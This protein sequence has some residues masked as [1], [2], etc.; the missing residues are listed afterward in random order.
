MNPKR[1]YHFLHQPA[2]PD[3]L[4][5]T[6]FLEESEHVLLISFHSGLI[7]RIYAEHIAAYATGLLEEEDEL[8]ER[9]FIKTVKLDTD[10]GHS[11]STWAI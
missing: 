1:R 6:R 7:E 8:P 5:I 10:I 9:I 11:P 2:N 4:G 3:S